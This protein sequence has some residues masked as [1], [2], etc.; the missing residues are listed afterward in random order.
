MK[1]TCLTS[2]ATHLAHHAT[3]C[4]I[5]SRKTYTRQASRPFHTASH[6]ILAILLCNTYLAYHAPHCN[7]KN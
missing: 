2:S 7:L 6:Y 3:H 1:T 5:K 4:L